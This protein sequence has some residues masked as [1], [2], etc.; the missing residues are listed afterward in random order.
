MRPIP[1]KPLTFCSCIF[2]R[3]RKLSLLCLAGS[4]AIFPPHGSKTASETHPQSPHGK[5]KTTPKNG[6]CVNAI[7]ISRRTNE[8]FY[9]QINIILFSGG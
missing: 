3:N 6:F 4:L 7:S 5:F 2:T 9:F 1:H 8:S